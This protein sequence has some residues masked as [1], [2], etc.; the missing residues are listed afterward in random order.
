MSLIL[1]LKR[2]I[3]SQKITQVIRDC[4]IKKHLKAQRKITRQE[5]VDFIITLQPKEADKSLIRIGSDGD[6]GY[7]IPNDL[8]GCS[9]CFSPGVSSIADFEVDLNKL[10]IKCYLA[11]YSLD[12]PPVSGVGI[13]FEKKF[14][15]SKE[16]N[17]YMTLGN[18]V[19]R[20][21]P[22]D[23][24]LILQMDIEGSEYAAILASETQLLEKFRIL[25]IEFHQ[26]DCIR[27]PMG[28]ELI[29]LT[30]EKILLSFEV[31]HI[32]PNNALLP[33]HYLGIQIPPI[34]EFTFLRKDRFIFK[35]YATEFPHPL[36]KKNVLRNQDIVLPEFWRA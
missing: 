34:M 2:L 7:L 27:Y 8:N 17:I 6:G 1:E 5:L 35:K 29:K 19:K 26:L 31:V 28:F 23:S 14:I 36:D 32:H 4:L 30:F 10:G 18:W 3:S 24:D 11:D 21:A 12:S 25:V 20:K 16:S 33:I 22:N 13:D 15:G 9:N